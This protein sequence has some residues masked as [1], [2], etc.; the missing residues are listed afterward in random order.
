MLNVSV[1]SHPCRRRRRRRRACRWL[2]RDEYLCLKVPKTRRLAW[3]RMCSRRGAA[4][5]DAVRHVNN[6]GQKLIWF[7]AKLLWLLDLPR[8]YQRASGVTRFIGRRVPSLGR[9]PSFGLG[10]ARTAASLG[11]LEFPKNTFVLSFS[12]RSRGTSDHFHSHLRPPAGFRNN[13]VRY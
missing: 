10:R 7:N 13:K 12:S 11:G 2:R 1:K 3:T 8:E 6:L 5:H 4:A 9:P